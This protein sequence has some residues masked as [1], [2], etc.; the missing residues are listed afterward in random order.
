MK[1]SNGGHQ[2]AFLRPRLSGRSRFSQATFAR[3]RRK[4]RDASI[5]D[6]RTLTPERVARPR[7]A[8]RRARDI[9]CPCPIKENLHNPMLA[10]SKGRNGLGV[11]SQ[12][13]KRRL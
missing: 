11:A 5:P 8:V 7:A 1:I 13:G 4:E 2:D 9:G 12:G 6:L 10:I 3:T